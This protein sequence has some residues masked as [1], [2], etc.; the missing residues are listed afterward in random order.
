MI[1]VSN[2]RGGAKNLALHL[3]KDENDHVE[4]YEMRGF[5][6]ENLI[7]ALNE[8][9]A[10]SRGTQCKQFLFSVSLNPPQTEKVN[11]VDFLEAIERIE[12]KMGLD[13]QP[14]AII[15]HEKEGPGGPRRHAHAVWSR[16]N[17][18][19]MKAVQLS[20]TRKKLRSISRELFREHGWKM[21]RGLM[22]S[23]ERDPKNFTLAEWQQ[24]KRIG[25]DARDIKTI[26]QD[27]WT[28]SDS[29]AAFAH[30]LEERGYKLARG[31]RRGFVAV[32]HQGEVYSVPKW[33]GVKTRQA[34]DRLGD[35]QAL[36]SVTEV[37][38]QIANEML[39]AMA[40]LKDELTLQSQR[41]SR[42]FEKRRQALVQ[43]QREARQKLKEKQDKRCIAES[44]TRQARFRPGLKGLW[45]R[46]R[47]EHR[48]IQRLN[49]QEAGVAL[50]RDHEELDRLIFR[51]L[52]ARRQLKR[53][54]IELIQETMAQKRGLEEDTK[55][56]QKMRDEPSAPDDRTRRKTRRLER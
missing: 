20:F 24:A 56:Y 19:E 37:K 4:V 47:G 21:P 2:Q 43:R 14:R 39:S 54:Y 16:I 44:R 7:G 13:D 6:S 15:F 45:D 42:E 9:Y 12:K 8:A 55:A 46:L 35:E 27:A 3:L 5:A 11:I 1:L 51:Q 53:P 52:E 23:K 41:Q 18:E 25:K 48:R 33:A 36:P 34:R 28:V 17:M 22:D 49:E 50:V 38:E 29:K 32:D 40:R 30:A 26:F 10:V 31:D